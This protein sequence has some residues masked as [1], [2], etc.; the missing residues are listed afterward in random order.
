MPSH[1][2]SC[3]SMPFHAHL[4]PSMSIHVLPCQSMPVHVHPYPSM[5]IHV[6]L[7]P[8]MTFY[9]HSCPSMSIH[10][11]LRPSMSFHAID[12][13]GGQASRTRFITCGLVSKNL[14]L[15]V[16]AF[17]RLPSSL[18]DSTL[19]VTYLGKFCRCYKPRKTRDGRCCC[20]QLAR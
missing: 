7:Y 18:E 4:C 9:D 13:M 15:L 5:H 1:V 2:R 16:L 17:K 12:C 19:R 3:P 10:A 6:L 20:I 8:S 14:T 11:L